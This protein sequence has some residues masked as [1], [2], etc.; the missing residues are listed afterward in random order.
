MPPGGRHKA[1]RTFGRGVTLPSTSATITARCAAAV[2][3]ACP[4]PEG[5]KRVIATRS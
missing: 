2:M 5:Y 3:V 4:R 1:C